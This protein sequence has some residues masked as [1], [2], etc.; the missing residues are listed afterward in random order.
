MT[1]SSPWRCATSAVAALVAALV[2]SCDAKCGQPRLREGVKP[3][4]LYA[5]VPLVGHLTPPLLQAQELAS[6]GRARRVVL[7]TLAF[8]GSPH[9]EIHNLLTSPDRARGEVEV[10]F[11]EF[12]FVNR[13]SKTLVKA[14][15]FSQTQASVSVPFCA[16]IYTCVK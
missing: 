6:T 3:F 8:Q 11:M 10:E 1:H 9:H 14:Q 4:V 13:T 12:G 2:L 16:S 7:S 15:G 5:A